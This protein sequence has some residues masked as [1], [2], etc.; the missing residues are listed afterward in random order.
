MCT[1]YGKTTCTPHAHACALSSITI[2]SC[3]AA[4]RIAT[5]AALP[6]A[7]A[8]ATATAAWLHRRRGPPRLPAVPPLR[9]R[10]QVGLDAL[11]G[12]SS[13]TQLHFA[14]VR[15]L[16]GLQVLTILLLVVA[17]TG[18]HQMMHKVTQIA[19]ATQGNVCTT[20]ANG[21]V[22]LQNRRV[23]VLYFCVLGRRG[24]RLVR[25]ML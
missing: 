5:L 4:V 3:L 10:T 16:F 17:L 21:P 12:H 9:F 22:L 20:T 24:L 19:Y 15:S 1:A 23:A 8:A 7:A 11:V 6:C 13:C 14:G 18:Q 2:D 25:R